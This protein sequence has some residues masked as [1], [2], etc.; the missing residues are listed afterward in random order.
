MKIEFRKAVLSDAEL[1]IDIYNSSFY[2][3]YI[4]YGECPAYGKT[5]K[6]MRRSIIDYPKFIILCDEKPVGCISCKELQKGIY[7]I[8]CL[9]VIPEFQ[10]KGIGT[11]AIEFVKSYY[12]DWCKFTLV[13]PIDKSENVS[14]YTKKC[15]FDIQ[16]SEMDGN[17]K[18]ARFVLER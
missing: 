15:G 10:G 12:T 13:T 5:V 6:M 18:V 1:L 2:S 17:V 16:S 9:C 3:D 7:E 8:G 4:K 11:S 14:F